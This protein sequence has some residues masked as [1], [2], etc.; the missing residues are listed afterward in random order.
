MNNN[1]HL[2]FVMPYGSYTPEGLPVLDVFLVA[3]FWAD[4]D[5]RPEDGGLVWYR[6]TTSPD[7][8]QRALSDIQKTY[9]TVSD[10][11]YLFIATWDHIG[12]FNGMTDKVNFVVL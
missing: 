8:L 1:G 2:S 12:Y 7:L 11:D 3:M 9:P 4:V 6:I 5:T 10:L